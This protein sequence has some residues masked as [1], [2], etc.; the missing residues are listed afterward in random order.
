MMIKEIIETVTVDFSDEKNPVFNLDKRYT[1]PRDV[2]ERCS[3]FVS[4][5]EGK[6]SL[7]NLHVRF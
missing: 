4:E 1:D 2:L 3:S 7:L 6:Y 5:S